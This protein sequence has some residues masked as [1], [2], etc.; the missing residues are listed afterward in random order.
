LALAGVGRLTLVDDDTVELSNLNRQLLFSTADLGRPKVDSAAAALAAVDPDLNV[1]TLRERLDTITS[2]TEVTADAD[3]LVMTADEP[4]Y[5]LARRVNQAC[6]ATATPWISA[7]QIPPLIRI[8]P[9]VIPGQTPCHDCQEAGFRRDHPQ[10]ESLARHRSRDSADAATLG[11]A[12]GTIGS[13]IAM[14]VI[15]H[16]T[17]AVKPATLGR[18]LI[19]DL[20][21]LTVR[22]EAVERNPECDCRQTDSQTEEPVQGIERSLIG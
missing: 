8:G 9:T 19:M 22:F 3:F 4:T 17:G 20:R 11:A 2:L 7:G 1:I 10:Y 18:A 12:S 13:L 15:H 14:E 5:E 6:L 21:T 16:L